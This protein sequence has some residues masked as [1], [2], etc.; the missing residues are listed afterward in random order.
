MNRTLSGFFVAPLI[1]VFLFSLTA[2]AN[3][4]FIFMIGVLVAYV[5]ALIVGAPLLYVLRNFK[6]L[7]WHYFVLGGALCALPFNWLYSGASSTHLEIYGLRNMVVFY[8]IG[9]AGGLSFWFISVRKNDVVR[10]SVWRE[11]VGFVGLAL[12]AFACVYIYYLGTPVNYEGKVLDQ[13]LDFI[14]STS[15]IVKIELAE[16]SL[17]E[18]S[19][20][21]NLPFLPGCPIFVASRRSYINWEN[22]YWVNGY[23]DS[24]FV[25]TWLILEQSEKEG[26]AKSCE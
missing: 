5:G 8:A 21:A 24:P 15:R 19:L 20:P 1:P 23:K 9:A 12:A 17:V 18:A 6:C 11:V 4:F 26:I 13:K 25:N 22:L 7:S 2:G 10:K 14:N 3:F 16:G